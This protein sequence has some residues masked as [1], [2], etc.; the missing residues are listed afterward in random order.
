M[1]QRAKELL[2]TGAFVVTGHA[3]KRMRERKISLVDVANVLRG[4]RPSTD[5]FCEQSNGTWRYRLETIKY[6]VIIAFTEK[7]DKMVLVT[8]MKAGSGQ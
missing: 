3:G 1:K 8:V 2:N 5:K 6:A 7:R 4:G